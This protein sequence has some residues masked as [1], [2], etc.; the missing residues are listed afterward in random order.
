M[1]IV[2][3]INFAPIGLSKDK[4]KKDVKELIDIYVT[5]NIVID[6]LKQW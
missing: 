2:A 3:K 6:A 5:G 1:D 4:L